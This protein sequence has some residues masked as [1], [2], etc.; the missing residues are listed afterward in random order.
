MMFLKLLVK[1]LL[2]VMDLN[3]TNKT[4]KSLK[5]IRNSDIRKT[6]EIRFLCY[7]IF[8]VL[9]RHTTSSFIYVL[10]YYTTFDH[11]NLNLPSPALHTKQPLGGLGGLPPTM[12]VKRS[13]DEAEAPHNAIIPQPAHYTMEGTYIALPDDVWGE[14]GTFVNSKDLPAL[15][16]ACK[17]TR[18]AA[19][20]VRLAR[21][22]VAVMSCWLAMGGK[23]DTLR[24][25]Y[26]E[27]DYDWSM[28]MRDEPSD[29]LS[30]WFGV[31]VEGGRVTELIWG[32]DEWLE[33]EIEHERT[34]GTIPAEIGALDGLVYLDLYNNRLEG[35]LPAELGALTSLSYLDLE[36]NY[37]EGP[38]PAELGALTALTTLSLG[39]ND[40]TGEIPSTL[41][42]LTNLKWLGLDMNNFDTDV[43]SDNLNTKDKVQEYL[44]TLRPNHDVLE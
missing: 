10:S 31:T 4:L 39:A 26:W 30:E 34:T 5:N 23:E 35:P 18:D 9:A 36:I 41:A 21:D 14:I 25:G 8:P 37:S 2:P 44:A 16:C 27:K 29:D 13:C 32:Y 28:K 15:T 17:T 11:N 24:R 42:N 1:I 19:R 3:M 6:I 20:I 7:I 40:F 33:D 38:L 43:P 12:S 22:K